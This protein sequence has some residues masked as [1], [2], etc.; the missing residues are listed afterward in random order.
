MYHLGWMVLKLGSCQLF[1]TEGWVYNRDRRKVRRARPGEGGRGLRE[2]WMDGRTEGGGCKALSERLKGCSW[3]TGSGAQLRALLWFVIMWFC[4]GPQFGFAPTLGLFLAEEYWVGE[5]RQG[6]AGVTVKYFCST[7]RESRHGRSCN[8]GWGWGVRA[9]Q[10]NRNRL[11]PHHPGT[12]PPEPTWVWK[13]GVDWWRR[14]WSTFTLTG[15]KR[16]GRLN[17][18]A[19]EWLSQ[20]ARSRR[21]SEK[22]DCSLLMVETFTLT[23]PREQQHI[24]SWLP[25][26]F[27]NENASFWLLPTF[28]CFLCVFHKQS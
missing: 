23:S 22:R 6:G 16:R 7:E 8:Q 28:L 3:A 25:F 15:D 24:F 14:N 13:I 26:V 18:V 5:Q 2:R 12:T 9:K 20:T 21:R 27:W 1:G 4:V 19:T 17:V 11:G 10:R